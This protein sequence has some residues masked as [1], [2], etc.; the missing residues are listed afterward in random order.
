VA[1]SLFSHLPGREFSRPENYLTPKEIFREY[2]KPYSTFM[3]HLRA[4]ALY[5]DWP[6]GAFR[7]ADP[8]PAMNRIRDYYRIEIHPGLGRQVLDKHFHLL[9]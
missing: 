1:D 9:R 6:E 7:F 4:I 2:R 8:I 5:G 3:R